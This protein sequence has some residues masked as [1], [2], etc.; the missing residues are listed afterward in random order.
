[1]NSFMRVRIIEGV[2]VTTYLSTC[3]LGSR[4]GLYTM[5]FVFCLISSPLV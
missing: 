5:A 3:L 4:D 1:M 2:N